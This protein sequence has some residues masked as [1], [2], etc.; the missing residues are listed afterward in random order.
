MK[1]RARAHSNIALVKYWGKRQAELNLPDV[2]SI[3][4]TLDTLFTETSVGFDSVLK[5]DVLVL[6]GKKAAE[7]ESKRMSHFLDMIRSEAG[8]NTRAEVE[9]SNNFPT[10]A[11]L[12]SSASA[13]AALALA[14]T[15]AAGLTLEPQA[16]SELAR[17]GSGSAARSIFGGFVE[18]NKGT[19]D[20]GHDATAYQLVEKSY[21]DIRVLVL[22]TSEQK[23][24]I[25][26]TSGM[27]LSHNTSPYYS[28]WVKSS[29]EDLQ[30]MRNAIIDKDFEKVG[31]LSEFSCLKMH[32]LALS[33]SPGLIYW[34]AATME[35][36]H[37]IRSLREKGFQVY[38]TIDAGPQVK[39][40]CL[41][42]QMSS[43]KS[44]LSEVPGVIK[45]IETA[46]GDGAEIIRE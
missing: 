7:R 23:K 26:S 8:I 20:D 30:E 40:L 2:G 14:G 45:I 28:A 5:E 27:A 13:F 31:D 36:M 33:S 12:A 41:P 1:T 6:N 9:S 25:S 19:R 21:W 24:N 32:A 38:F 17:K 34:N 35:L 18:M 4:I 37:A 15:N 44:A 10:S 3:S 43:I 29:V 46:L 22:I 11:G 42:D 39:A 16:L